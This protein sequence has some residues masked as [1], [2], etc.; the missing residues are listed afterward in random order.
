MSL[1]IKIITV[2]LVW[3]VGFGVLSNSSCGRN[4]FFSAFTGPELATHAERVPVEI[5]GHL[6]S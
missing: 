2:S 4:R 1:K 5:K 3:I 6:P